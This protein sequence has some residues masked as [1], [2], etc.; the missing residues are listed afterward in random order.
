V[1]ESFEFQ[2]DT[3]YTDVVFRVWK[4]KDVLG[5]GVIALFPNDVD[6]RSGS[7]TSYEH[8][9]QHGGA[10]YEGVIS[11]T[12]PATPEESAAL[13]RELESYPFTYRLRVRKRRPHNRR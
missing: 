1:T 3:E 5:D 11:K 9:G 8:H 4:D 2:Q 12:R 10:W 13:K 7:V 6:E